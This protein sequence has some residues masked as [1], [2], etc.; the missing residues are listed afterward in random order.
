MSVRVNV[1]G[2]AP[3]PG[4]LA[5]ALKNVKLKLVTISG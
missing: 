3:A 1:R 2:Q 4:S 5:D